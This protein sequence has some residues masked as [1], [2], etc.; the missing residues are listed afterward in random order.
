[1]GD[2]NIFC[3]GYIRVPNIIPFF[4]FVTTVSKCENGT[5]KLKESTLSVSTYYEGREL[6]PGVSVLPG[7][8]CDE[9]SGSR[10]PGALGTFLSRPS[11]LCVTL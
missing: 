6:P 8:V 1:M 4:F 11:E 9:L 3:V 5:G 2:S 7:K 10:Q